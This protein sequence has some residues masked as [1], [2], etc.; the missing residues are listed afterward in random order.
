MTLTLSNDLP[1]I[2]SYEWYVEGFE[3]TGTSK[4]RD[5]DVELLDVGEVISLL[6]MRGGLVLEAQYVVQDSDKAIM[7]DY[8]DFMEDEDGNIAY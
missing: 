1:G 3:Q 2:D 7:D 4:S 8:G 6:I 5:F